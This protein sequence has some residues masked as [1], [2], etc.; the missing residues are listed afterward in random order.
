MGT[1]RYIVPA[2]DETTFLPVTD[3]PA[4]LSRTRQVQG[5]LYEKHILNKGLLLHP[6]TGA[7][8][9][10][11]D[12]FVASL[13]SNFAAGVCP[14]VQVP[15][16]NDK[17]EHV[18]APGAN[19][20]EVVG[21]SERG[22]KVYSLIDA[23]DKD[24]AGKLGKTMLGASA[25]LHMN[26]TDTRNGKKVGPTLLH[27]AVTNRPYVTDLDDYQEV[28]AA[29]ADNTGEVVV[30]T[31]PKEPAV[32]KTKDEL[33][34]ELRDSHGIDVEA[35]QATAAVPPAPQGPDTAAL[36]AAIVDALKSSGAVQLTDPGDGQLSQADLVGAV[37]ELA[38]TTKTQAGNIAQLQR[39]AAEREVDG[40][41]GEGRVLPKQ[42]DAFVEMALTNRDTMTVLL[43]D[44]PV[45]KLAKQE[46]VGGVDGEQRHAEDIDAEV[47]R[48]T[49][50]HPQ[51]FSANGTGQKK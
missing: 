30:L 47:A 19:I 4:A 10:V 28:L 43:P 48:L 3:V 41:I 29:T 16:A 14:I 5:T 26:Y 21:I 40:Y 8:I 37:V 7:K 17:N 22:G 49:A 11:D 13:K 39:E 27:V 18:E 36:S 51:V 34:A 6:V 9:N 25:F 15:L 50:A 45:V 31:A 12:A 46:G 35:L 20:G 42:R 2:P 1:D 44:E 38:A 33:I 32:P 23:R 24:A